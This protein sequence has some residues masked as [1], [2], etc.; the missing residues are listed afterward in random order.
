MFSVQGLYWKDTTPRQFI[1]NIHNLSLFLYVPDM[2][3]E[4]KTKLQPKLE[5]SS[6]APTDWEGQEQILGVFYPDKTCDFQ[7]FRSNKTQ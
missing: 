6:E 5:C 4:D 7:N 2:Y 3:E 1:L